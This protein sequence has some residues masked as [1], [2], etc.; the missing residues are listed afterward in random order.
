MSN[1]R[2]LFEVTLRKFTCLTVGDTIRIPHL[3]KNF[4]LDIM[5]VQPNGAA[6][7]IETDC[8]VDFDEPLGYKESKYAQYEKKAAEQAA[9]SA[10]QQANIVR[11][12]QKARVETEE[13]NKTPSFQ[14][15]GGSARRIDGKLPPSAAQ[16]KERLINDA[17]DSKDSKDS[18]G[19][20]ATAEAKP[21]SAPAPVVAPAY[22]SRI[23]DKYSKKK[24]GVA[25]FAGT[26]RK[27]N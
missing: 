8:N 22:E 4:Y 2:A 25:A 14:A 19:T 3:G 27:L 24:I 12:L 11:T 18:K 9:A 15:F 16:E 13:D 26:A 20:P 21:S 17:K 5:E 23:G 7:I 1:P 10:A 6:S